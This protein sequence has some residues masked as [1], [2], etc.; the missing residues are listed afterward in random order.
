L[1]D[2]RRDRD[3]TSGTEVRFDQSQRNDG[4]NKEATQA[5]EQREF[6]REEFPGG[7]VAKSGW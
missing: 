4:K 2:D 7:D 3:G 5:G 6:H 1:G